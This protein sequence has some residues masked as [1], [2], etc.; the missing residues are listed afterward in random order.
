MT[1][2]EPHGAAF[3]RAA[4]RVAWAAWAAQ[5]GERPSGEDIGALMFAFGSALGAMHGPGLAR[6]DEKL[7]VAEDG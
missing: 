5:A 3:I 2:I 4:I 6:L 7:A 1:D